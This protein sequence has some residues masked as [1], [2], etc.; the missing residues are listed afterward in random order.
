MYPIGTYSPRTQNNGQYFP[1][2]FR[3][4]NKQNKI[5]YPSATTQYGLLRNMHQC[6]LEAL[7]GKIGRR[8]SPKGVSNLLLN[9]KIIQNILFILPVMDKQIIASIFADTQ[10]DIS[11]VTCN[12]WAVGTRFQDEIVKS[13]SSF[14]CLNKTIL[15]LLKYCFILHFKTPMLPGVPP[16][17]PQCWR[18]ASL[19]GTNTNS[20]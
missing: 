7:I 2:I 8:L 16:N 11:N 20:F 18:L 10:S 6:S 4:N 12:Y 14:K 17:P 9:R 19:D 15:N 3:T 1:L 5:L 13:N